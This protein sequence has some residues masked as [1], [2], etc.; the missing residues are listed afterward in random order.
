MR[1]RFT[2]VAVLGLA[3]GFAMGQD[4][5][6]GECTI[7]IPDSTNDR[8]MLFSE[9]DG[10]LINADWIDLS[11]YGAQTPVN[12]IQVGNEVWVSDQLADSIFRFSLDGS[13]HLGTI[14][15]GMDNIRGIEW[16]GNTVYVTNSGTGNGAPG[17]GIVTIDVPTHTISGFFTAGDDGAGDPFDVLSYFG[18][19]LI[20]DIAG[21]DIDTFSTGGSFMSVFHESNG[22]T[23]LNFPEQ[24]ITT[25]FGTV[26]VGG[27]SSPDGVYE[28][29][30]L[31]N[32]LNYWAVGSGVRGVHALENGNIL[33]TDG[34]GVHVLDPNTL[35]VTDSLA[36][37]SARFAECVVVPAPGAL[38]LAGLA[39]LTLAGRRR[40]R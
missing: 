3:A 14:S 12:A 21:D 39:G 30:Q 38:A 33:F 27:F 8:V 37:V 1:Q 25:D 16:V 31:G 13:T 4:R 28:F 23:D 7:M 15:G 40:T 10:S 22:S 19:L 32:E 24:M 20:N 29:D 36:G 11:P 6:V 9:A 35:S 17:K 5:T 34:N 18:N 2:W 26:L